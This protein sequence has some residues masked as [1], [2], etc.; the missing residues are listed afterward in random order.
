MTET[1]WSW[2]IGRLSGLDGLLLPTYGPA[3]QSRAQAH[4]DV[5][6]FLSALPPEAEPI[7]AKWAAGA[8]DDTVFWGIPDGMCIFA[9]LPYE[10]GPLGGQLAAVHVWL[11]DYARILRETSGLDVRVSWP[12]PK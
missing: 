4:A 8:K 2:L 9:I 7:R 11:D 5:A 3:G 6:R 10:G 1:S 12:K